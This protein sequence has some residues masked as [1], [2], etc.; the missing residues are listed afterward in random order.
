MA[1]TLPLCS[2]LCEGTSWVPGEGSWDTEV[3]LLSL[4]SCPGYSCRGGIWEV[5]CLIY[6]DQRRGEVGK[7]FAADPLKTLG[8]DSG[9]SPLGPAT[10]SSTVGGTS[11]QGV[12]M[13]ATA[14]G[15][16][17]GEEN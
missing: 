11:G 1:W 2:G 13:M 7:R 4:G 9:Q 8:P 17:R 6:S 5:Q 16:R 3:G 15:S 12:Q 14:A 10:L